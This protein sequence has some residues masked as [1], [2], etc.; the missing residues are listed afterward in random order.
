MLDGVSAALYTDIIPAQLK[1][2]KNICSHWGNS[3]VGAA[4]VKIRQIKEENLS[5]VCVN[6]TAKEKKTVEEGT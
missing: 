2:F 6:M 3:V 1:S 5:I 4:Y